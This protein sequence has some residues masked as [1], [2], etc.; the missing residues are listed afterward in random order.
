ME[1]FDGLK[2]LLLLLLIVDNFGRFFFPSCLFYSDA[3]AGI[4]IEILL[5][6]QKSKV[7][8]KKNFFQLYISLQQFNNLSKSNNGKEG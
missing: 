3:V 1:V 6:E 2:L 8:L 7:V 4:G 5:Q